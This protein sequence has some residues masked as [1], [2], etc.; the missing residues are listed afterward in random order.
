[1]I[2]SFILSL[3]MLLTFPALA[4][5]YTQPTDCRDRIAQIVCLVDPVDS[6][7]PDRDF[8]KR[9]CMPGSEHYAEVFERHFDR[10]P[11]A[12]K[13]MYCH[14]NKVFI[15]AQFGGTAFASPVTDA[16]GKI[17]GGAVGIRKEVLDNPTTYPQ[18]LSW[19]EETSFGGSKT[20]TGP[21][22]NLIHY[23]SNLNTHEMFIDFVL[24]HEFGHLFD[25][26]NRLNQLDD[27]RWE[28]DANGEEHLVGACTPKP[29]SWTALSWQQ[30]QTPLPANDYPL[31][32]ETCFYFCNGKFLAPADS[33]TIFNGLVGSNFVSTYAA[34]NIGDDWAESFAYFMMI[35]AQGF[36][37]S[38]ETH[39]N[40]FDLTGH[41][42][43]DLLAS[44]R[45][46]TESFLR[47]PFLYPGEDNVI[48]ISRK[49]IID[50]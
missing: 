45:T 20:I 1:M 12:I 11:A 28:E 18:W 19:K 2:K 34:S 16:N 9:P 25:M 13:N 5:K 32:K 29:G 36:Q 46:Y 3:S 15:E 33:T 35:Q 23:D 49:K 17:V 48:V 44:K 8:I 27:C 4:Q 22:L 31:R 47:S 24:A 38:V 14:L 7:T 50:R 26:A 30:A 41:F 21:S 40:F 39:G 37:L 43:S 6:S 42:A 10:S